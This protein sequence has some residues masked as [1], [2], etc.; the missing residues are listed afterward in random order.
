MSANFEIGYYIQLF[1]S[2]LNVFVSQGNMTAVLPVIS[3]EHFVVFWVTSYIPWKARLG[4]F[5][6]SLLTYHTLPDP[7][8]NRRWSPNYAA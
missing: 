3:W 7:Y 5:S 6:P 2:P 1:S 8:L 4:K